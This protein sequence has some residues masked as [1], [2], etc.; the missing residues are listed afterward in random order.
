MAQTAEIEIPAESDS[1]IWE[2]LDRET[3]RAFQAFRVYLELGCSRS[4][5][6]AF[7][8]ANPE[9]EAT[10]NTVWQQ[11]CTQY[12]WQQRAMAYDDHL[13]R[14]EDEARR[15]QVRENAQKWATRRDQIL[16]TE[17]RTGMALLLRGQRIALDPTK[18]LANAAIVADV[19][20]IYGTFAGA[21]VLVAWIWL[22]NVA[23]LFGAELNAEIERHK[24]LKE[25]VPH[26]ETLNRPARQG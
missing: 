5:S 19:G 7:R 23:L 25:G 10:T 11:W 18:S 4:V 12:R 20:A 3:E 9:S 26:H 8:K 15:T 6:K 2:R 1:P 16:E 13:A 14:I 24:E 21:I 22:T 17:Y